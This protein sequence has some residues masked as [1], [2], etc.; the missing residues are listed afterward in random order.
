[1]SG[2]ATKGNALALSARQPCRRANGSMMSYTQEV[3]LPQSEIASV[4][5]WTEKRRC[6]YRTF[7]RTDRWANKLAFV[8]NVTAGKRLCGSRDFPGAS[9]AKLRAGAG[10]AQKGGVADRIVRAAGAFGWTCGNDLTTE[11]LGVIL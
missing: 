6:P 7:S 5:P 4:G 11:S 8:E 10:G 9:F 2:R 3:P 1:M